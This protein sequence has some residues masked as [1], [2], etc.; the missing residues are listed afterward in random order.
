MNMF[1]FGSPTMQ[2]QIVSLPSSSCVPFSGGAATD[3]SPLSGKMGNS[4]QS[5]LQFYS[6]VFELGR[7]HYSLETIMLLFHGRA[8]S[9]GTIHILNSNENLSSTNIG[10][11]FGEFYLTAL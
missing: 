10:T 9:Y 7:L 11:I 1:R 5:F 2:N 3:N 4:F 6:I 8:T